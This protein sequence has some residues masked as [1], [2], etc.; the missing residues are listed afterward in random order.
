[1]YALYVQSCTTYTHP[2]HL[3][4][5]SFNCVQ[6]P[7]PPTATHHLPPSTHPRVCNAR[8]V[9]KNR[10]VIV[11]HYP[12]MPAV[13][14]WDRAYL[15]AM[16]G[17]HQAEVLTSRN[18]TYRGFKGR[19]PGRAVTTLGK[20]LQAV[21]SPSR[22]GN[23]MLF[24]WPLPPAL[25]PDVCRPRFTAGLW[26]ANTGH[27]PYMWLGAHGLQT[28]LH[29]DRGAITR[30]SDNVHLVVRGRKLFTLVKPM[31]GRT[32]GLLYMPDSSTA[33]SPVDAACPDAMLHPEYVRQVRHHVTP[34]CDAVVS[35]SVRPQ[36]RK[37]P[38]TGAL[39]I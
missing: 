4:P 29:V 11:R 3:P 7:L 35:V 25:R 10:P 24:A 23:A 22:P 12:A 28:S 36:A 31:G 18:L 38:A 27:G 16:A 34:R 33:H 15:A 21:S 14:R 6:R 30:P 37:S 19:M 2:L 39:I 32:R 1:M 20:L 9:L 26:D 5:T 8:F 13:L 17:G